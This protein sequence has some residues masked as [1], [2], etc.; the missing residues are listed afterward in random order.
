MQGWAGITDQRFLEKLLSGGSGNKIKIPF[1]DQS[2]VADFY[3]WSLLPLDNP[4][5]QNIKNT[6]DEFNGRCLEMLL[7]VAFLKNL[8]NFSEKWSACC[9]DLV[10]LQA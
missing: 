1:N 5:P 4:K 6:L 3:L 8:V 2:N 7:K 9:T 10:K